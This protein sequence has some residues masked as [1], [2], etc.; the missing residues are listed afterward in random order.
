M[1]SRLKLPD[2][3]LLNATAVDIDRAHAIL[4]HCMSGVEFGAVKMLCPTLPSVLDHRVQYI[5]IPN[6]DLLGYNQLMIEGLNFCVQ[7]RHCLIVQDDGFILDPARWQDVFLDYD[8]IGAPWDEYV[9]IHGGGSLK[10]DKNRVGNG[11][12]SLRSKKLLE[13]TSR[14]RYSSFSFPIMSEDILLCHFLYEDMRRAGIRFASP[15]LAAHFLIKSPT[16]ATF[17][18]TFG[19]HG[20]HWLPQA[21]KYN[22]AVNP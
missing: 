17:G 5:R 13:L 12:F 9:G 20:K 14:L 2:V 15:E 21:Q 1:S 16:T 7:T 6:I 11:G 19:F 8:Y 3:T 4:L 18:Q 22:T 10:L